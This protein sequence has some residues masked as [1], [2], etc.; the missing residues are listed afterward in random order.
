M[1]QRRSPRLKPLVI[2]ADVDRRG[3]S[4]R[5]YVTNLSEGG[6]F[7]AFEEPLEAGEQLSL[8]ISLPWR[9]GTTVVE[10]RVVWDKEERPS[11]GARALRGCG[12]AFTDMNEKARSKLRR[13][14]QRF[15]QLVAELDAAE[16][17]P[18]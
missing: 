8:S 9:L 11:R 13:Y 7:L 17:T 16:Q 2:R 3:Q 12:V 6:A 1:E 14:M 5:G 10:A 4:S 18:S 15:H